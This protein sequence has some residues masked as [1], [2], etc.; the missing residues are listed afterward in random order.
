MGGKHRLIGTRA[1]GGHDGMTGR[2]AERDAIA[3][4]TRR[5]K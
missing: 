2:E 5:F 4:E 3:R 1:G